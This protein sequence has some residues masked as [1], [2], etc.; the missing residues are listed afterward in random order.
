MTRVIRSEDCGNSPKNILLEGITV[1]FF[2]GD[3]R[4]IL[5]SASEDIRWT[6]VGKRTYQ[7]KIE[8]LAALKA[9]L[10]TDHLEEVRI[11]HVV[12]HGKAGA[13]NGEFVQ[14]G[15]KF[16]FC[17]CYEFGSAKGNNISAVASYWIEEKY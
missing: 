7:G 10:A 13:V 8:V 11:E 17:H 12:S 16:A 3:D 1:A 2:S 4:F 5:N 9:T 15:V 14:D 6:V